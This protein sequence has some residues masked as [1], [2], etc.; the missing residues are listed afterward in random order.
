MR[1]IRL[2]NG[3]L[4][5]PVEAEPADDTDAGDRMHEIGPDHPEYG[6]WLA[7]AEDGEDPKPRRDGGLALGSQTLCQAP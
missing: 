7:F 5:T 4:L 1:A 6:K 2:P 3:N